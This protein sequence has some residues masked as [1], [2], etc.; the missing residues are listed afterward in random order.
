MGDNS[1]PKLLRCMRVYLLVQL[2]YLT[3][4]ILSTVHEYPLLYNFRLMN[5][6]FKWININIKK[7]L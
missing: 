4:C 3:H 1:P 2:A 6:V 7:D 5:E